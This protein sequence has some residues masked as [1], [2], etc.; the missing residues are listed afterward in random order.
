MDYKLVHSNAINNYLPDG[1]EMRK[2]P[3]FNGAHVDSYT[4]E[5]PAWNKALLDKSRHDKFCRYM[6]ATI[7][8]ELVQRVENR[9]SDV[10][11]IFSFEAY[12][13]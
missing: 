12:H 13:F 4:V 9:T 2:D 3:A 7:P 5:N 1:G 11:P 8:C 10:F 6:E